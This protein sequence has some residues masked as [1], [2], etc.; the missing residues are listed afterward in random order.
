MTKQSYS[1]SAYEHRYFCACLKTSWNYGDK[2]VKYQSETNS[3][4]IAKFVFCCSKNTTN[5]Y[6]RVTIIPRQPG[7]EL[8]AVL[9]QFRGCGRNIICSLGHF[10]VRFFFFIRVKSSVSGLSK[11]CLI[12]FG[13]NQKILAIVKTQAQQLNA[14][15][16]QQK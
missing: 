1:I 8:S 13:Q 9:T 2:Y 10:K 5:C 11:K 3:L 12:I 14:Q 4:K 15:S 6:C 16:Y 7:K